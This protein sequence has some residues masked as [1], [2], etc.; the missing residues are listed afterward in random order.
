MNI[1]FGLN[2]KSEAEKSYELTL[3]K[4]AGYEQSQD[5][6][7]V[8]EQAA[9]DYIDG[10]EEAVVSTAEALTRKGD[11]LK[12]TDLL[13]EYPHLDFD[14]VK[15]VAL[16]G[17]AV[18]Q[19]VVEEASVNPDFLISRQANIA[20]F[21]P[22]K[23]S[24]KMLLWMKHHDRYAEDVSGWDIAKGI[25]KRLLPID[26]YLRSNVAPGETT[27]VDTLELIEKRKA[28]INSQIMDNNI[29]PEQF[30]ANITALEDYFKEKGV[31]KLA[32]LDFFENATRMTPGAEGISDMADFASID[33]GLKW[34][35]KSG[36]RN[37]AA[38]QVSANLKT[39]TPSINDVQE[40]VT[41]TAFAPV[42][43]AATVPNLAETLSESVEYD[44]AVQRAMK[45]MAEVR[46]PGITED[47]QQTMLEDFVAQ[48]KNKIK[49]NAKNALDISSFSMTR[50]EMGNYEV[51]AMLGTGVDGKK[52]FINPQAAA[53]RMEEVKKEHPDA[54][55]TITPENFIQIR[56]N[57]TRPMELQSIGGDAREWEH[58][59]LTRIAAGRI[60]V[61]DKYHEFDVAVKYAESGMRES[62]AELLANIRVL[63]KQEEKLLDSIVKEGKGTTKN[64]GTWYTHEEL[65]EKG[66]SERGVRAYDSYRAIEDLAYEATNRNERQKLKNAN[67]R[68]FVSDNNATLGRIVED[69]KDPYRTTFFDEVT[70]EG[71]T[72]NKMTTEKLAELKQQG[73]KIVQVHP[74]EIEDLNGEIYCYRLVDSLKTN[75]EDIPQQI[76][77]YRAGG[78]KLYKPGTLFLK[79]PRSRSYN[80]EE[81]FYR[82]LTLRNSSDR[83][84]IEA[85]RD[86]VNEIQKI[87]REYGDDAVEASKALTERS[88]YK[89][90]MN[91]NSL[92][93]A[94]KYS[95]LDGKH[96]AEVVEDG[97]A[98]LQYS[99][100]NII[101]DG[102]DIFASS[103]TDLLHQSG[104][105]RFSKG[106]ARGD[107]LLDVTE[108]YADIV[109]VSESAKRALNK[110][111]HTKTMSEYNQVYSREF[112]KLFNKVLDD[113]TLD[114][115]ELIRGNHIKSG[116]EVMKSQELKK[117]R[118]GAL[119]MKHHWDVMA[120]TETD[121]DRSVTYWCTRLANALAD[122]T[123]L[124]LFQRGKGI[125][126][127]IANSRLDKFARGL[128]YHWYLGLGST[129]QLVKQGSGAL[130]VL[131]AHP[132]SGLKGL[133]LYAPLRI[134]LASESSKVLEG[135]AEKVAKVGICDKETFKGMVK[136]IK[137]SGGMAAEAMQVGLDARHILGKTGLK[138][139]STFFANEGEKINI[140][141][142]MS[143][144]YLEK[145]EQGFTKWLAYADDLYLNMSK[146]SESVLQHGWGKI[147]T[148]L[149]AQFTG[150]PTRMLEAMVGKQFTP[151]Q[152]GRIALSQLL[153]WGA[154]GTT[155]VSF[156]DNLIGWG[157]DPETAQDVDDGLVGA[158]FR[159]AGWVFDAGP[160][161]ANLI[162]GYIKGEIVFADLIP[163]SKPV[164]G[165]LGA[166]RDIY[167]IMFPPY[168]EA[169]IDW[170]AAYI[171]SDKNLP[172]SLTAAARGYLA[173]KTGN[174]YNNK[175]QQVNY[176]RKLDKTDA[177]LVALGFKPYETKVVSETYNYVRDFNETA[178]SFAEADLEAYKKY[179]M[180]DHDIEKF[181]QYMKYQR[182][183][184]GDD[185]AMEVAISKIFN[186]LAKKLDTPN[187]EAVFKNL[188]KTIGLTKTVEY[189]KYK[190]PL[191]E[192]N[193]ND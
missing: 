128:T 81:V 120:N 145:G 140:L 147:P 86:E 173:W 13:K 88:H 125:H 70:G 49:V 44:E 96:N 20:N 131:A 184:T 175:L 143:T 36:F 78:R 181:G 103:F 167:N 42:R 124:E 100:K 169:N 25:G 152:K 83:A 79:M 99:G 46:T 6:D 172:S 40:G 16:E 77:N 151:M 19:N 119:T 136:A 31:D 185:P 29:S 63:P 1:D 8:R 188:E 58:L 130:T 9:K 23:V 74:S 163:A 37:K 84:A 24:S 91:I 56:M 34:L 4:E 80:G 87:I 190:L 75:V 30:D 62:G 39:G 2:E 28:Y 164:A 105:T 107:Q 22:D 158:I 193:N 134:A 53:R 82:P 59:G 117:L 14:R 122:N 153:F 45:K 51:T 43:N 137:E 95:W 187:G 135:A 127:A 182:A 156:Y 7:K 159:D 64:G 165:F 92:E 104:N 57:A 112:V 126:Q 11:F 161:L 176:D 52:A 47:L 15:N 35:L 60:S 171:V 76:V 106:W 41:P 90:L 150:Y 67:F 118:D 48:E 138:R 166:M 97:A 192:S 54:L 186:R 61:P 21:D 189:L 142:A 191:M 109:D 111:I 5:F 85:Y 93:D 179:V 102:S 68:L 162:D 26:F 71:Y 94:K 177:V 3:Q 141:T 12:A 98:L 123:D 66:L 18:E 121:W 73:R 139:A 178:Q 110:M 160:A 101:D 113:P 32:V 146:A 168:G 174:Y 132:V 170:A 180:V 72:W 38:K 114:P 89:Y 108:D 157:V 144:A 55:M 155:G 116:K 148:Q 154:A 133:A 33:S 50:D 129:I 149:F 65:Y 10:E 69:V 115:M 27:T 17:R 183:Y